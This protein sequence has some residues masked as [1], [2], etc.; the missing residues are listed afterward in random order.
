LNNNHYAEALQLSGDYW[1][2]FNPAEGRSDYRGGRAA[3]GSIEVTS[4]IKTTWQ[5]V[6]RRE[7]C[8]KER[9]K[10]LA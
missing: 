6:R 3:G 7:R 1:G 4:T 8:L 10:L 9:A 2:H 5:I